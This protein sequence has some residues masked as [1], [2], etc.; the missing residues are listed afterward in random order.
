MRPFILVISR[1]ALLAGVFS[2]PF[3]TAR[4]QARVPRQPAKSSVRSPISAWKIRSSRDELTDSV[5]F[6]IYV[7]AVQPI[8][9]SYRTVT[10]RL[11]IQCRSGELNIAFYIGGP[12]NDE[13][14][15]LRFDEGEVL[16]LS[17]DRSTNL[18]W[19]YVSTDV[20]PDVS[21]ILARL[22]DAQRV[23]ARFTPYIASPVTFSFEVAG[24]NA[25][26]PRLEKAGCPIKTDSSPRRDEVRNRPDTGAV[27]PSDNDVRAQTY[28]EFQV[29][30]PA[31]ALAGNP[32]PKYPSVLESSGLTGE[33]QAQFVV[34]TTG[35][36]DMDTFKVLNSTHELFT[37]AVRSVLPKMQFSPASIGGRLVNQVVQQSFPF[38]VA[39]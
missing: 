24:L 1:A 21:Q 10:P 29:E 4:G 33:V 22:S 38:A 18:E 31:V 2:A 26:L 19:L 17:M 7:D 12:S 9:V 34:R 3:V 14:M 30:K 5:R 23:R 37:Q 36:V 27:A 20:E 11:T 28:F 16:T 35:K 6:S 8:R 13:E 15:Q 39:R 32:K 25:L